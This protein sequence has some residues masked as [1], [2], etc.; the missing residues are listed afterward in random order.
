MNLWS[1]ILSWGL[2]RIFRILLAVGIAIYAVESKNYPA[3]FISGIL[4]LQAIFNVSCFGAA[5]SPSY[6]DTKKQKDEPVDDAVEFEEI[7]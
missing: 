2:Q 7:K 6:T 3:L 5:C 4:L 1:K